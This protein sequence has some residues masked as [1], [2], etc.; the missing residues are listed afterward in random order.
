[1]KLVRIIKESIDDGYLYHA[2]YSMPS[3]EKKR[4][5]IRID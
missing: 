2:T 4:I 5:N 1:M 3:G